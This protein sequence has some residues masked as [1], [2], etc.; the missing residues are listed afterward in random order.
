M[1]S[2][3]VRLVGRRNKKKGGKPDLFRNSI[4]WTVKC[5]RLTGKSFTMQIETY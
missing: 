2:H 1:I 3:K 5:S 4:I